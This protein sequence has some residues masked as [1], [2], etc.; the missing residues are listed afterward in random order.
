MRGVQREWHSPR[1]RPA[2][3]RGSR[4]VHHQFET[5]RHLLPDHR[6][7]LMMLFAAAALA[8]SVLADAEVPGSAI[9]LRGGPSAS[10]KVIV[11]QGRSDLILATA[12]RSRLRRSPRERVPCGSKMSFWHMG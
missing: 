7:S 6:I 8:A 11:A 3:P 2:S 12:A 10:R 4:Y 1:S 5:R 9:I